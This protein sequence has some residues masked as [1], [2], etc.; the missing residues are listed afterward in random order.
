M[1]FRSQLEADPARAYAAAD[2]VLKL[3]PPT[4]EEADQLRE[5][6]ILVS[7]I[8]P[9]ANKA[10]CEKLMQRLGEGD[11]R[12]EDLGRRLIEVELGGHTWVAEILS[13]EAP[14]YAQAV[15]DGLPIEGPTSVTHSSG[16]V[17]H[18]WTTFQPPATPPRA[19]TVIPV[20]AYRIVPKRIA[21]PAISSTCR[22]RICS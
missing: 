10:L 8:W 20:E 3:H 16:E 7:H 5:G 13:K 21:E 1:L 15:W 12:L 22:S 6:S 11:K 19:R 9:F 2:I 14:E 4:P 18:C 17:L